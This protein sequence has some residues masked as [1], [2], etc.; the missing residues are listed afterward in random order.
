MIKNYKSDIM[1][2]KKIM[3]GMSGG[4]DSSV[5]AYLLKQEGYEVE[6]VYMKLH[7][8]SKSYH[9]ENLAVI[10]KVTKFLGIK[11]HILDLEEAFKKE[12]YD[13]FIQS[14]IDG[15][16]PNPCVKCNKTIKFGS[17]LDFAKEHGAHYLAT[18][19]YAKNDG[20]FIYVAD[21]LTKDQSYFLAQVEKDALKYMMFPMSK[22]KKE[23]IKK[24]AATLPALE[25]LATKKESQE[26]CFVP[27]EYTD[28]LKNH[29]NIDNEGKTLDINGNIVGH[30]KG[31][32]HYTIGKRKGFYVH[33]AHDPHFVLKTNKKDNTITVGKKEDL[34]INHV[35]VDNLNMFI[36][37][38][39]FDALVKLRYRS[40]G[41][42]AHVSI[43]NNIATVTL[44]ESAFG[45]AMGQ[46]A[47]FYDGDKVIGSGI[48]KEAIS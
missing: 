17:M 32:M 7:S 40:P 31:Y 28:I 5:T 13:Y 15:V 43:E 20:E 46:V 19:H 1:K 23:D 3:L 21:D 4:V 24:I 10:E 30:H 6:G 11:Y 2:N 12:V 33:G 44:H 29:A 34:K 48:I 14:Y 47:V 16:T 25:E 27:N 38:K 8:A 36:L 9:E 41:Q 45:V 22:Y 39:E 42:N 18:G 26:I 37:D 35:L